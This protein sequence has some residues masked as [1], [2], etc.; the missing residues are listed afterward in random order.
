MGKY[1]INGVQREFKEGAKYIDIA[2]EIQGEYA[3]DI[4]LFDV[5][6]KLRE[7][8]QPVSDGARLKAITS[9]DKIGM[10]CYRRS[11][12]FMLMK[13]VYNT[14]GL[15]KI[16]KVKVLYNMGTSLYIEIL[17][18]VI[19]DKEFAEKAESLMRKYVESDIPVKKKAMATDDAVS[20]FEKYKMNDKKTLLEFRSSSMVNIYSIGKFD[21]YYFG[22]MVYSTGFLKYFSL[23]PYEGGLLLNLPDV[24]NP[25]KALEFKPMP[26]I[27][28]T[29]KES[30]ANLRKMGVETVGA[31]NRKIVKGELEEI[32]VTQETLMERKIAEIADMIEERGKCRFV[33]IAGPSSSGKTTFSRRLS[34]Q[35]TALG[36]R[37]HPISLDDYFINYD[38][39][40][41]DENGDPDRENIGALDLKLFASDMGKLLKGE[42]IELPHYNFKT[43]R[44]EYNGRFVRMR[45]NDI[46]VIEG[47]H[48]LNDQLSCSMPEE[49]KFKIYV[50]PITQLNI[51]ER[52]RVP[53]T[54]GR[55]IRRIVRDSRTRNTDARTT[56]SWWPGVRKGEEKN[57][58]PYQESADVI[59]NSSLVYELSAL[60][61]LAEPLLYA[62]PK[63]CPEYLEAKR[64]LKFFNY[65]LATDSGN[66]P[67]TSLVREF[68][69]GSC[70]DAT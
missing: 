11:C 8:S 55:L 41:L 62:V 43:R 5:G 22:A 10:D 46:F 14:A 27:F 44:R 60:K 13:A 49:T 65:V 39:M 2:R 31:L 32:I 38:E 12:V 29:L 40:P 23:S 17:G 61:L 67:A 50:S 18:D 7:L 21:D 42:K 20:L 48:G 36:R 45:E 69:G 59:F 52:N 28:K 3:H 9:A 25:E 34:I 33:L 24:K 53:T 66:I 19:V 37:P 4:M 63:D 56:I 57:I 15:D 51:D 30:T 64:L 54:D 47:I 68:I 16:E 35:L 70:F 58:F 6:G 26:K 1:F